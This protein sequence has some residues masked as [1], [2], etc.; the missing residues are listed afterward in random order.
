MGVKIIKK[1]PELAKGRSLET[2]LKLIIIRGAHGLP[3][4]TW[5][6]HRS[7]WSS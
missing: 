1:E 7:F 5:A 3:L 4:T 2:H 6:H